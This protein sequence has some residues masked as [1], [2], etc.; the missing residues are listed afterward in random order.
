MLMYGRNQ[1]NIVK[2]I[3]LQ[4]KNRAFIEFVNNIAFVLCFGF[5]ALRHVVS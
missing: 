5:L 1:H 2:Q 4:W 3:I